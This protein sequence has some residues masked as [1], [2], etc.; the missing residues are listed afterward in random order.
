VRR[1]LPL[2]LLLL[3]GG[4]TAL[5]GAGLGIHPIVDE[6][7]TVA[8]ALDLEITGK[9]VPH[10]RNWPPFTYSLVRGLVRVLVATGAQDSAAAMGEG[11]LSG[12]WYRENTPLHAQLRLLPLATGVGLV[13]A[14]YLLGNWLRDRECG[15]V[16]AAIAA[17]APLAVQYS[18]FV[19]TEGPHALAAALAVAFA[20]RTVRGGGAVSRFGSFALAGVALA[21][22]YLGATAILAAA[23]S[24]ALR[25]PRPSARRLAGDLALGGI[26]FAAG[27]FAAAPSLFL[28]AG[29]YLEGLGTHAES[30]GWRWLGFEEEPRGWIF[31]LLRSVPWG[32]GGVTTVAFA[33]AGLF[34]AWGRD[35]RAVLVLLAFAIPFYALVGANRILFARY[36][37]P[38]VPVL[39]ALAGVGAVEGFRRARARGRPVVATVVATL[40]VWAIAFPAREEVRLA[41]VLRQ[42]DTRRIAGVWIEEN[43][44]AG[45]RV[46]SAFPLF[47]PGEFA[48][49][50]NSAYP[51]P[52]RPQTGIEF[53]HLL[54]PRDRDVVEEPDNILGRFDVY[55]RTSFVDDL[56][57]AKP[58]IYPGYAAIA[59]TL[60]DAPIE[61]RFDP[62]G[63]IA[64]ALP[65][66][67]WEMRAAPGRG[68]EQPG[69][70]I[71]ILRLRG[72]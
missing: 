15:L 72:R 16:A 65:G 42:P 10:E 34:L 41:K 50:S 22:K 43:L 39:A 4:A 71:E 13:L 18:R 58:S 32:T 17:V 54:L 68:A 6:T 12:R 29:F 57:E 61:K 9:S 3:L 14:T 25:R 11:I 23:A 66:P 59:R 52:P 46:L 20:L 1:L 21:A 49:F 40:A 56:L 44:P 63:A 30:T 53:G 26:A 69:P 62:G 37:L 38:L 7:Q 28:H 31:H 67:E 70:T 60:R 5:R 8:T 36:L 19:V 2:G 27:A 47:L 45:T 64:P 51:Y 33:A 24:L 35:R 55:L 48:F